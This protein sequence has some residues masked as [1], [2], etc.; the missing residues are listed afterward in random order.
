MPGLRQLEKFNSDIKQLG[1][2]VEIRKKR[3]EPVFDE[4]LP[5]TYEEDDSDEFIDG[6][7]VSDEADGGDDGESNEGGD[8]VESLEPASETA[9]AVADSDTDELLK[10]LIDGDGLPED[11]LSDDSLSDDVLEGLSEPADGG[12]DGIE[13]TPEGGMEETVSSDDIDNI[14]GE[15]VGDDSD[16]EKADPVA[17][18]DDPVEEIDPSVMDD[19]SNFSDEDAGG[20]S[21]NPDSEFQVTGEGDDFALSDD[22]DIEG[23]T[24]IDTADMGRKKPDVIDFSKAK[25]G[26]DSQQP[27]NSLTEAEYERFKRNLSEYPLNLKLVIEET[28]SK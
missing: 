5:E 27:K 25:T 6:L 20:S 22:F 7:P 21:D 9:D 12:D 15:I 23:F 1:N 19:L 8:D 3:G 13:L 18:V 2:E 14:L 4:P 11:G 16:V 24:N 28:I 26:R 10:D 17:T